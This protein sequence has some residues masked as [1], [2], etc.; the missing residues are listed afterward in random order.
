MLSTLCLRIANRSPAFRTAMFP[1]FFE[2]LARYTRRASWWTFMNY[3]YAEGDTGVMPAAL[4]EQDDPER[5]CRQLYHKVAGA[6]DLGGVEVVEISSGRGGGA[7]YVCRAFAPRALTGIDIA[8]SAVEFSRRVHRRPDLRFIQGCAEDLPLFDGSVDAVINIE[9]SFCYRDLD[10]FFAEVRRVLRPGGYFLYADLRLVHEVDGLLESLRRSGLTVIDAE[11]ITT[12]VLRALEL[13]S[14]RRARQINR[15]VPR[16]FRGMFR[17]FA[18]TR[19]SRMPSLMRDGRMQYFRFV[20]QRPLE[21]GTQPRE[22]LGFPRR[23]NATRTGQDCPA[24]VTG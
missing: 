10:R 7:G 6:V 23:G 9:A 12:N 3:G 5:F 8:P 24:V 1:V 13:D 19:G 17:T 4:G 20:L 16:V 22:S 2:R 18:G 15:H 21:P 11:D 14:D